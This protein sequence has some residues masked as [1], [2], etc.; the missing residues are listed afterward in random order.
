MKKCILTSLFVLFGVHAMLAQST[1]LIVA[2]PSSDRTVAFSLADSGVYKPI[3]WGLDLAWLSESNVRRG[4]AFMGADRVDV[5]RSSFQPTLPLVNGDL[6]GS[7]ITDLNARL[8]IIALTGA[9]TKIALNCDHPSVHSSY[10]GNAV[11]WAQLMDATTRRVQE[12]GRKVVS[13]APF[14]EPD[15]GWAQYTG[16]NGQS[17]FYAIAG[18]LRKNIRFDSIRICGGNTLNCDQATPWYNALKGRLDEGNTHQL[19]GSFDNFASF[20]QTVRANGDH[21]TDDELHNVMEAM[22][23]VEYGMQTGIW[24]G[25]AELARGEFVKASD[26][27]R[28][29]YAEHRP[30]WTAASVYRTLEGKIQAFGG[31]SERQA[32]TTSYKFVSKDK[33]VFFD[34]YG[35]QREYMMVL[36]GGTGYQSGQTNAERVVNI[37]WGEDI[38]P[39]IN[40]R[41]LLVNRNSGK[42]MEVT[43]GSPD[44]GAGL[45]QNNPVSGATYQ[46][47]N[48][49]PVDSRIGGDYSYFGFTAVHSGKAIDL[50]NWSLTNGGSVVVWDDAKGGN[51]Q[52]YL[53]YS[54]DGWFYIRS[55]HSA[56][57]LQV[58]S[59]SLQAGATIQHW[60]KNGGKQQQWRFIP[61]G[62]AVEFVAPAEPDSLVA[63]PNVA[64]I[65]LDWSA[66]TEADVA[67]YTIFRADSAAGLYETIARNVVTN[68]FVDH[69]IVVGKQYHYKIKAIDKSLNSSAYSN[70]VSA[71]NTTNDDLVAHYKFD[72]NIQD[73]SLNLNH[74][75][76]YGGTSYATGKM[77]ANALVLN[78]S[79]GFM[80]LPTNLANHNE[81]TIATWVYWNGSSGGQRIFD[82]G[83][84]TTEYMYLT[85]KMTLGGLRFAIRIGGTEQ[86]LNATAL[87]T[88]KW[89]HVAVTLGSNGASMYV[90]G[91]QVATSTAVTIRP[92]DFKPIFNYIGRGQSTVALFNGMMD[93]F[94]VYNYAMTADEIAQIPGVITGLDT[95]HSTKNLSVWSTQNNRLYQVS[96]DNGVSSLAS[97]ISVYNTKGQMVLQHKMDKKAVLD[98]TNLPSDMYIFK[99]TNRIETLFK[100]VLVSN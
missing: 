21:A 5:I 4:I 77:G 64:S 15:Y 78:G 36:P 75:A 68:T 80:Q 48:V 23:G 84:S 20:F 74:G 6:Q 88:G 33:D 59:S 12:R 82:F 57:C 30:N 70:V 50:L 94:R 25:T 35:P 29:A 54:E 89:S 41:Y 34:G 38:Q 66:N 10:V 61:V 13:V 17:D 73:S 31:T 72:G 44:A 32:V 100:K 92:M 97:L 40:G 83:N 43:N 14:N 51:Q 47:W 55:R 42:V 76:A 93:D 95:E 52:W 67:G 2:Q 8:N 58:A 9:H 60:D 53:E 28:L 56:K 1:N 11:N 87:P 69:S 19:A 62:A 3:I 22:V 63:T 49:T 27:R 26:G 96:Y 7:Q 99:L 45:R 37:T 86:Q 39:V 81:I 16:S 18:E 24:W 91:A 65:R 71:T 90:N 79:T 98:F 46:Q 85:P